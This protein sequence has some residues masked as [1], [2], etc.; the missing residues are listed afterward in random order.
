MS[1]TNVSFEIIRD[2]I[3][4]LW[5]VDDGR[6]VAITDGPEMLV[7]KLPSDIAAFSLF[8][9]H[10]DEVY[11]R[12][13][14]GFKQL[15]R[16][17]SREWDRRTLSFVICRTSE[18]E[19]DDRFYASL[20]Q[21]PLFCRKYVI[22]SLADSDRQRDE[23]LRLPF[24]PLRGS[25]GGAL[26]RP[27]SAQDLLQAAGLS[28]SLARNLVEAGVRSP[29]R[30]ATDLREGKEQL[31][32][33]ICAPRPGHLTLSR[34]RAHSRL[35]SLTVEGF[36]V[37]RDKQTFPLDAPV[38]VLYGPNGLGKT[39]FFDAIDYACT[40]RIGRLNQKRNLSE[41]ARMATHLDKTPGSG[42]VNVEVRGEEGNDSAIW[43]LERNTG[44]WSNAWINGDRA[45]RKTVISKL[46]QA[47]WLDS[48]PRQQA[49]ENLFRATHLFG[50]DEHELLAAFK[51]DSVIPEAF[52][53]DM[54]ALQ[55]YSQGISKAGNV[56]A[57]LASY[58][59]QIERELG[60]LRLEAKALDDSIVELGASDTEA[61]PTPIEK[62]LHDL[63]GDLVKL[64]L[65]DN[66]P[67]DSPTVNA[68]SEWQEVLSGE[69]SA[70]EGLISEVRQLE[71]ELPTY[72][73]LHEESGHVRDRLKQIEGELTSIAAAEQEATAAL[74]MNAAVA[75]DAEKRLQQHEMKRQDLR[76]AAEALRQ[77][78]DLTN[79]ITALSAE[80]DRQL[81]ERSEV[82][83]RLA[84][85][86]VELS[87]ATS[88]VSEA[89][90][91]ASAL[92]AEIG[93]IKGLLEDFAKFQSDAEAL[94]GVQ[95]RLEEAKRH[96]QDAE[97]RQSRAEVELRTAT[98]A[99]EAAVPDYE[100]ALARQAEMDKLLDSIQAHV[101]DPDCPLCGSAFASVEALLA[102]IGRKRSAAQS[103]SRV[104]VSFKVLEAEEAKAKDALRVIVSDVKTTA[105]S[106]K[107]LT[108]LQASIE[109][110]F[111]SFRERLSTVAAGAPE[112][113]ATETLAAVLHG[114]EKK[115]ESAAQSFAAA[116]AGLL[117][118]EQSKAEESSRR[119]ATSERLISLDRNLQE[120]ND[121][122]GRL[123]AK[124]AQNDVSNM[125]TP[126]K[127]HE[128]IAQEDR[129]IQLELLTIEQLRTARAE[130]SGKRD[131][132]ANQKTAAE[133]RRREAM[134]S[135]TDIERSIT[136]FEL[137]LK[138][139]DI[140]TAASAAAHLAVRERLERRAEG[141]R[142]AVDR[143]GVV[144][145]ALKGRDRRLRLAEKRTRAEAV[146]AEIASLEAHIRRIKD[147]VSILT[148]AERLLKKERQG[149]IERH[150]DAYG[151]MITLIQQ[152]LRSV[153]GF[154]GVKLEAQK[155]ET[156]AS[157]EWRK[158]D[159]HVQ[160]ADFF[161]DSQKQILMLSIFLAG[162]LR[163]T[164]SGFAPMLLDDP[165]THFDDL[166]AYGF[167]EMIRGIVST[168]PGSWQFVISTCEEKLFNL[169]KK[170]FSSSNAIFYQFMGLSERGPI[171]EQR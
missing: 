120:L 68:F 37:Y 106:I 33:A 75:S 48:A 94:S 156:K 93:K 29:E 30:I 38:V 55:D 131:A 114:L 154:G 148:S 164:W 8:D 126:E 82:D 16:E 118:I 72:R 171:I 3:Q 133:E 74:E 84:A 45:D 1:P 166:N 101:H 135:L 54:L 170:K 60:E 18:E 102:E 98:S 161:S 116:S 34:P 167:I 63:R 43:K 119:N 17:N 89:A 160:P 46:T 137:K 124:I 23:L 108:T 2:A 163:Q 47:N 40:G 165:V 144:L 50:Q 81:L 152:R 96:L 127:I 99:R 153:Y 22:R 92:E 51:K 71:A 14:N 53:S 39:S 52:I 90:H 35:V 123:G 145:S 103:V 147:G 10:P 142:A 4:S 129:A 111:K 31:P 32:S 67:P 7:L 97:S 86:E 159:V 128:A 41:F 64:G 65:D 125:G 143:A 36:R 136:D 87:K 155:G 157:V 20:E 19:K 26:Q 158:K 149:S 66:L 25:D 122:S 162:G 141:I 105:S 73:R 150:I 42:C 107:E 168:S 115:E 146:K 112:G 132:S 70:T 117:A 6:N 28:A 151:P 85:I 88:S 169:M 5:S 56:T 138:K 27:Q 121:R 9:S 95:L 57:Q 21:D 83:V 130:L 113:T 11:Q 110:R 49:Y 91:V 44:D 140:A 61:E 139:F 80:R 15:Y 59:D 104:T 78:D 109:A 134:S 58:R 76:A 100:R 24:F 69:G 62:I 12:T 77:R 79:K 13:Y